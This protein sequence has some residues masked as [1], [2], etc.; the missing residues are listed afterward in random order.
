MPKN[1]DK[2]CLVCEGRTN[3]DLC[4]QHTVEYW[5]KHAKTPEMREFWWIRIQQHGSF[6]VYS[7]HPLDGF[8]RVGRKEKRGR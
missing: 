3:L 6:A 7:H 4:H 1:D 8:R 2:D 5:Y